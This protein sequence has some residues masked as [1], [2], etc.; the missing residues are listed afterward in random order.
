M[1]IRNIGESSMSYLKFSDI[2]F[3]NRKHKET[4]EALLRDI[5]RLETQ[6][7]FDEEFIDYVRRS[8]GEPAALM[9]AKGVSI[10]FKT[11]SALRMVFWYYTGYDP[12][13][14]ILET[15]KEETVNIFN[16]L[17]ELDA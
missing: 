9:I 5:T 15:K 8:S 11:L 2:Q 3:L 16:P 10:Q 13:R 17:G 12:D 14:I 4:C 6:C 7:L 1:D